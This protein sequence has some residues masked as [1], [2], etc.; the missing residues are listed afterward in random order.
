MSNCPI[1]FKDDQEESIKSICNHTFC[2]RCYDIVALTSNKC[3][4]CRHE[5]LLKKELAD[6]KTKDYQLNE[7]M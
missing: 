2:K 4:M 1:C 6:K 7:L 5:L 3:P